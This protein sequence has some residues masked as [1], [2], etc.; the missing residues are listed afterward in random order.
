[1]RAQQGLLGFVL[2]LIQILIAVDG[3]DSERHAREDG[4]PL[5]NH[6]SRVRSRGTQIDVVL[7]GERQHEQSRQ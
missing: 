5:L 3:L 4:F 2:H 6:E 1:L 7:G